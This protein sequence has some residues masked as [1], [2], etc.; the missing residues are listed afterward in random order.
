MGVL[1]VLLLSVVLVSPQTYPATH[2][3]QIIADGDDPKIGTGG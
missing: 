1:L 2:Q 3:P